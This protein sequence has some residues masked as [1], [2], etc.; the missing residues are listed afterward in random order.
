MSP[1]EVMGC[2]CS[3]RPVDVVAPA[4]R[5]SPKLA[6]SGSQPSKPAEPPSSQA[7][8]GAK[9]KDSDLVA[10]GSA[11]EGLLLMPWRE[12][13]QDL[14]ENF[15]LGK[16]GAFQDPDGLPKLGSRQQSE[17]HTWR[18]LPDTISRDP[19]SP[20]PTILAGAP[21]S[22]LIKQGLVGDCS[23]ISALAVLAEHEQKFQKEVLSSIIYPRVQAAPVFNEYGQYGCQFFLNGTMRKVV[24]DDL[25][26]VK[27]DGRLL[28]AHS[29]HPHELWV[30]L[31]EKSYAKIMGMSYDIQ[32]S[33]PGT[34]VFH[35]TGWLPETM[36]FKEQVPEGHWSKTFDRVEEGH[37]T[38]RCVVCV[39]TTHLDDAISNSEALRLGHIEGVGTTTGLVAHHAYPVLECKKLGDYK[40]LRL[41]NPW[42]RVR[43]KGRFGPQD[44]K[45]WREAAREGW[46]D[47]V[48]TL[49]QDPLEAD[50]VDTGHFWIEWDAVVK[51][52]SHLYFSWVP[53]ALGSC[54]LTVHGRFDPT[55]LCAVSS[56]PDD[57]HLA[58]FNPQFLLRVEGT[59]QIV[60]TI[61]ILLSRHVKC[62]ANLSK[63]YVA[64][65]VHLGKDRLSCPE[66]PISQGIYSNGECALV[67]LESQSPGTFVVLVSQH[68]DKS[69]FNF[70]LQVYSPVPVS[71][72]PLPPTMQVGVST[73][74]VDG[75]WT[76]ATA[77]GCSNNL[78][79][80][81]Q[82]P[83][84]L[85]E[86]PQ[87]VQELLLFLEC[88]AEHS[89]NLRLFHGLV[90]RPE[91]LRA[92]TSTGPYRQ[93][94]CQVKLSGLSEGSWVLIPSTFRAGC[95]APYRI[96]WQSSMNITL[97]PHPHAFVVPLPPPLT[98]VTWQ[99]EGALTPP[100]AWRVLVRA[101]SKQPVLVA[102]HLQAESCEGSPA[103]L[104]LFR[105]MGDYFS[106]EPEC[107]MS[108]SYAQSYFSSFGASVWLGSRLLPGEVY[109]LE[110]ELAN[111]S[112]VHRNAVLRLNADGDV[113]VEAYNFHQQDAPRPG[114]L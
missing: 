83:Q 56:L 105:S 33:N 30:S 66:A 107:S 71:M 4:H 101:M 92:A 73:G 63:T 109:V 15:S 110:V 38:G 54:T 61:W 98:S 20:P 114:K 23:L 47:L 11:L 76:E 1:F 37:R 111:D 95:V 94:C 112:P 57:T 60:P 52:F 50:K 104:R 42:G 62:R 40:L 113:K 75:K 87:G 28:C 78:W 106:Q 9:V 36:A 2:G 16:A 43:W 21:S 17:L 103:N 14:L 79:Q 39:G 55:A 24:V 35:L 97:T 34:D 3:L 46:Q 85:L 13:D 68:A 48:N 12:G 70:T 99:M 44:A 32:G 26:P 80:Y 77:G 22:D 108:H 90:A 29:S 19:S 58:A 84:W 6:A 81:F 88:A 25:V 64:V 59:L 69:P 102:G 5:A 49:G 91:M 74:Y 7:P 82:N 18:R 65:H 72:V 41:K 96:L 8:A 27:A 10:D 100:A 53:A 51:Y 67:K 45:G 86:I 93:G 31:L 89:V